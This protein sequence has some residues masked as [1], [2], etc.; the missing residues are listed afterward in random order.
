MTYLLLSLRLRWY[1]LATAQLL[2]RR[3]QA[4]LL[5]G[6]VLGGALLMES[7]QLVLVLLNDQHG[8]AWHLSVIGLSQGGWYLWAQMQHDQLRGGR[9]RD[10]AQSL[11]LSSK[12]W[13]KIDLLVLLVSDTPL[14]LPFVAAAIVLAG[15]QIFG[16][17]VLVGGM[18]IVFLLVTQLACQ[19]AVLSGKNRGLVNLVFVDGWVVFSLVLDDPLRSGMLV[20]GVVAGIWMLFKPVPSVAFRTISRFGVVQKIWRSLIRNLFSIL[21]PLIRLSVGIV[22][23]QHRATMLG[24]LFNCLLVLVMVEG[25]MSIWNYDDRS[26]P[27][28]YITAGLVAL[29]ASGLFRFLKMAHDDALPF[30]AALPMGRRWAVLGDSFAVLSFGFPFVLVLAVTLWNHVGLSALMAMAFVASFTFLVVLLRLPQLFSNRNAVLN[31]SLLAVFW[32]F[33]VVNFLTP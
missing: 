23:S 33:G 15:D 26:L 9:F 20:M 8:V 28:A 5:F 18:L 13:R 11:P 16:W 32:T 19:L 25:L 12:Q 17:D 21:P 27:A 30:T 31:S 29:S 3:W 10:F 14:F 6:G 2:L 24:K 7:S 1:A 22:Y 4:V